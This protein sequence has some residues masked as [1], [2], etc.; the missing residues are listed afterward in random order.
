M[1]EHMREHSSRRY[2][3]TNSTKLRK[4]MGFTLIE[5]LIYIGIMSVVVLVIG[6]FIPQ[7]IMSNLYLQ[8]KGQTLDNAR[9]ALKTIEY[10][11]KRSAAIYA[12]TSVFGTSPGQLS[13]ESAENAPAGENNTFIDFYVDNNRLYLKK[14][15]NQAEIMTAEKI[16][17]SNLTFTDLTVG[18]GQPAVRV[19]VTA[20]YDSS[21]Q[22]I[23][24]QSRVSLTATISG[25]NY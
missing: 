18:M 19:A 14:E 17:I 12:P 24:E 20:Y 23:R 6:A 3:G 4:M 15:D 25:R 10:E 5:M 8:A 21:L 7:L 9:S 11:L 16:V 1:C 2:V 13:L 22:T